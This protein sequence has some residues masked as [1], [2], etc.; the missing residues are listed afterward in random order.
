MTAA[1]PMSL[2]A[3]QRVV[4]L[5][6][7]LR[8]TDLARPCA[9]VRAETARLREAPDEAAAIAA[10]LIELLERPRQGVLFAEAG[11]RS[12]VGF[13][14][15][16]L[17]RLGRRLMP[18]PADDGP[19]DL[20]RSAFHQAS[21]AQWVAAVPESAWR[22]LAGALGIGPGG[23]AGRALLQALDRRLGEAALMLSC[24][25]AG[26]SLDREL[27]RLMP[28]LE[29]VDSPFLA[30]N[31]SLSALL[32]PDL[33]TLDLGD[34]L[35]RDAIE[36]RLAA[37]DAVVVRA[38]QRAQ[39][40]GVTIRLSYLLSRLDQLI[41]RLRL[42]LEVLASGDGYRRGRS[43]IDL[44]C[45]LVAATETGRGVFVFVADDLR[46]LARNVTDHASRRGEHYIAGSRSELRH[47]AAAA[48][49]GGAIIALLALIKLRIALLHL[50]PLTEGLLFSLNYGLGF[51]L[52][53]LLGFSVA[54]KQPAMTAATIAARL[55][56]PRHEAAATSRLLRDVLRSQA[57]A[58]AGN[59]A[60]ALPVAC[61][62]GLLW[63]AFFGQPVAPAAKAGSLLQELHP[64]RSGALL[65]AAIA[66]VGLFLAGLVSGFFDNQCR[67]GR[68]I[69]RI[70]RSSYL[71][72]LSPDTA[73]RFA[74]QVDAHY[75]AV[76]GNLFF[77]F[78]LGMVGE[79]ANLTGLPLDI[80]HVAFST[81]N[82]GMAVT[83]VDTPTLIE[84]WPAAAA[85]VAGIALVN[86]VVSFWLALN[87]AM[88]SRGFDSI[89]AAR[90]RT[91]ADPAP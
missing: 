77:G 1:P 85:G 46:L 5:V 40:A 15:E 16:L 23:P 41:D 24:R 54:T 32:D 48:A 65:F 76:M 79:S 58:V 75:G 8:P 7:R 50:P 67:Y 87:V 33:G 80:R 4:A 39:E 83:V 57:I 3:S 10:A 14:L 28:E 20:M 70:P 78:F 13:G 47:M 88:L 25:L 6:G 30:Q 11:V 18:P 84:A 12:A 66:G 62:V 34:P 64:L 71:R 22:S 61:L 63:V 56:G 31:R 74:R 68:F 26:G 81:A 37:C 89:A 43:V 38:R 27:L 21:D 49:G 73:R 44:L 19:D 91:A 36:Q 35:A 59:V 82:V 53:H 90:H 55:D 60:I 17:H 2:S 86:L 42:L 51:V 29:S 52:I 72:W 45:T 9:A 69:D